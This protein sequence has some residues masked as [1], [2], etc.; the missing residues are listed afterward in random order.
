[1]VKKAKIETISDKEVAKRIEKGQFLARA[2]L[3]I[4][5]KPKEHII[6]TLIDLISQ[7]AQNEKY[8]LAKYDIA[9]AEEVE[10]SDLFSTFAE[11]EFTAKDETELIYFATDYMPA[12]IEVIEPAERKVQASYTSHMLTEFV[13]RL[14]TID[15][16]FK[17]VNQTNKILSQSLG[18]MIKNSILIL[19]NLG[20]RKIEEIAK[21]I[22]VDEDQ[23]QTF[24]D[25]LLADKKIIKEE[26]TYK[27][28]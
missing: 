22:G 3:E 9:L 28:Q 23:T 6:D 24:L 8:G 15:M 27:L 12:S 11:V 14:H 2:I 7:I 5:G 1:M 21:I 16:E 19:L 10:K 26:D 20:P 4:V 17:K 18:V 25:N 13:G